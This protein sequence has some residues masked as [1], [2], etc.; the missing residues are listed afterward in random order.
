MV[1]DVMQANAL[2]TSEV[3]A[4]YSSENIRKSY[5][6][7]LKDGMVQFELRSAAN[8]VGKKYKRDGYCCIATYLVSNL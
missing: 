7:F 1:F 8:T 4:V 6:E 5:Y 2:E 3:S